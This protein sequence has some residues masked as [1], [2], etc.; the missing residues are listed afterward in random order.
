LEKIF[1]SINAYLNY[2]LVKEDHYSQQ[3]PFVFDIY[4]RLLRYLSNNPFGDSEIESFRG[5]LLS[6]PAPIQ[7]LDLGAGSKKVPHPVRQ[8]AAIT[9]HSTSKAKF[10]QLYQFFC[11]ATPAE[12]VVE[13]GTCVGIST[14]YLSKRTRGILYSLEGSE[15]ILNVARQ[16]PCPTH[17]TFILGP[18]SE[19]LPKLIQ[20]IPKIDFALLDANHTYRSTLEYFELLLPKIQSSSILAIGDIH[21]SPEMEKAWEEI[22]SFPEVALSID[23]F[24]CG[25]LFFSYP[26]T[27]SHLILDV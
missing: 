3:S 27:K 10:C 12:Y 18:I 24:E 13:L 26:G 8:I 7:V 21:W 23:F 17:T 19:T 20:E 1:F 2:W 9:K 15:E 6:N 4:S 16:E 5:K 11:Q 25:I 14:R 22:K